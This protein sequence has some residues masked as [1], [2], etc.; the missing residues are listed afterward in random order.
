[1]N[2]FLTRL[3]QRS[4]GEAPLIAPRLPSLFAPAEESSTGN[5]ADMMAV[6]DPAQNATPASLPIQPCTTARVDPPAGKPRTS[7]YPPQRP[8]PPE[9]SPTVHTDSAPPRVE[10]MLVPVVETTPENSRMPPPLLAPV[11]PRPAASLKPPIASRKQD[12][13]AAAPEPWLP[14]LPQRKAESVAPFP[15]AADTPKPGDVGT[16]DAPTVHITIGRVEVRANIAPP[17]ATQRPRPASQPTLSL[18]DYLK[19]GTGAS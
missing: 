9:A 11:A 2:D 16:P 5:S 1:M 14:L 3:A 18:G 13:P 17:P 15:V 6:A 4:M 19:R 7:V 12:M 8:L 10:A